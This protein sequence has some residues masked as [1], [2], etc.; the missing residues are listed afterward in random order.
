MFNAIA[1]KTTNTNAFHRLRNALASKQGN[2]AE[3][4]A[5]TRTALA[6]RGLLTLY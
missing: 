1:N 4:Q 2:N 5:A 6:R 3:V